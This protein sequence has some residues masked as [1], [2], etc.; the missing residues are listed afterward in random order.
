MDTR[1]TWR[2]F[3]FK[4]RSRQLTSVQAVL[5][6]LLEEFT[7]TAGAQPEEE[8]KTIKCTYEPQKIQI[9]KRENALHYSPPFIQFT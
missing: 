9:E 1:G 3:F 6:L 5:H 2:K 7:E 8:V 4:K